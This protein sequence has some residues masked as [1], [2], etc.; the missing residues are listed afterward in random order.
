[1]HKNELQSDLRQSVTTCLKELENYEHARLV[2]IQAKVRPPTLQVEYRNHNT[3]VVLLCGIFSEN[4]VGWGTALQ[5]GRTRVRFTIVKLEF[6]I[7]IILSAI[8]WSWGRL[9]TQVSIRNSLW[10]VRV[11]GAQGWKPYQL[12]VKFV[13]KCGYLKL[14]E[15]YRP[16]QGFFF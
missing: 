4:A 1:M 15:P 16:V 2:T 8:L 3:W 6:F 7:D 13:L 9:L 14:L 10:G 11:A 5:T 12:H